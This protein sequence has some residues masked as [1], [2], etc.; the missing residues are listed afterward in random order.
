M[1][2]V[3]YYCR[4]VVVVFGLVTMTPFDGIITAYMAYIVKDRADG[5]A[6][7]RHRRSERRMTRAAHLATGTAAAAAGPQPALTLRAAVAPR[8]PRWRWRA[9]GACTPA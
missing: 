5:D 7:H 8:P 6:A 2:H 4:V 9:A 3:T 1:P